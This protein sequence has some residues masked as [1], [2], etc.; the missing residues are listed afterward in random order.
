MCVC[1]LT[2]IVCVLWL[3]CLHHSDADAAAPCPSPHITR[4]QAKKVLQISE[5]QARNTHKIAYDEKGGFSICCG[6]LTS[7]PRGSEL[8]RSP[9]CG[10]A[11]LPAYKG[12][13][14]SIDGMAQIGLE[15][16]GLVNSSAAAASRK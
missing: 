10:A 11:Y 14:C 1:A 7:I 8:V 12:Q 13:V 6:S 15:T 9:Y 2:I 4:A 5:Q 16:L 3:H